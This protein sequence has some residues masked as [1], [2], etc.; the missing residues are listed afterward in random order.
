[1]SSMDEVGERPGVVLSRRGV[2]GAA[3]W[4]AP[5]LTMVVA[6]P[7]YAD[8]GTGT[9]EPVTPASSR[10]P[11][12]AATEPGRQLQVRVSDGGGL[13]LAGVTVVFGRSVSG[14]SWD[15]GFVGAGA[16]P[17]G[18]SA[19]VVTDGDGIATTTYAYSAATPGATLT[20][21]AETL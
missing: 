6:A 9:L 4:S 19:T 1:M 8:Y 15:A 20:L 13:P 2:L 11:T 7:A 5:V 21:T 12:Y 17:D 3:V 18:A 14:G 16:A 10:F